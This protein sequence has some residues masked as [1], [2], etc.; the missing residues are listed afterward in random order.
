MVKLFGGLLDHSWTGS[1]RVTTDL[2]NTCIA[3]VCGRLEY[4]G[5]PKK[6]ILKET[7]LHLLDTLKDG[8]DRQYG[9]LEKKTSHLQASFRTLFKF[10]VSQRGVLQLANATINPPSLDI[11][12]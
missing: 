7:A 9:S 1:R 8:F 12:D 2:G 5:L 4:V 3:W 10:F 11:V 6:N